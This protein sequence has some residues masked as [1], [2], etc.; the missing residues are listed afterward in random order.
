M[1][2]KSKA[3]SGIAGDLAAARSQ[4]ANAELQLRQLAV[5]DSKILGEHERA[6]LNEALDACRIFDD[7]RPVAEARLAEIRAGARRVGEKFPARAAGARTAER[8]AGEASLIEKTLREAD[9]ADAA[10]TILA[11]AKARDQARYMCGGSKR[12]AVLRETMKRG[13]VYNDRKF[14]MGIV[15]M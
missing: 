15:R 10:Y 4:L 14:F 2:S 8:F 9:L 11:F 13:G 7:I 12:E 5:K 6:A 1:P 3:Q